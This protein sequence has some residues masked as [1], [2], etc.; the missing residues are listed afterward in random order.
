MFY[1]PLSCRFDA[2]GTTADSAVFALHERV[3]VLGAYVIVNANVV[4]NGTNYATVQVLG[5]DQSTAI[6]LRD[7]SSD[8]LDA[9][10]PAELASENEQALA[11]FDAGEAI[12]VELNKAGGSGVAFDGIVVLNCRQARKY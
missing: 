8:D 5:N 11:I 9:D 3:E 10:T 4:A 2:S 1:Y 6:Y 7:T 12:K